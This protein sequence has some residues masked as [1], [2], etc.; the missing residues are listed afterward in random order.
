MFVTTYGSALIG[1]EAKK[2]HIEVNWLLTGKASTLVGLPDSAIRESLERI[3]S[4]FKT[5]GY[6]FPRTK[7]VINL[8]PADIRKSGTAFDLPIAIGILAASGQLKKV[9]DLQK[10]LLMG[11]LALDGSI[12]SIRGALPIALQAKKDGFTG[13]ILPAENT[14]EAI[15]IRSIDII[16]ASHL[17]EIV[18][19][20]SEQLEIKAIVK[21]DKP[22]EKEKFNA[23][24]EIKETVIGQELAKRALEIAAAG[25]HHLLLYGAPGAGKT[26]LARRLSLLLPALSYPE[27]IETSLIHSV[28]GHGIHPQLLTGKRP[29]RD[30]HHSISD[31]GLIGG[32]RNLQPGEISLAHHGVL[33]LDELPEFKRNVLEALRQPLEERCIV[34]ARAGHTC[35]YPCSFLLVAAMNPCPCGYHGHPTIPCSCT[36]GMIQRY[37]HRI[38]GPLLDR[39]DLHVEVKPLGANELIQ[40]VNADNNKLL[41]TLDKIKKAREIQAIRWKTIPHF[42]CNAQANGQL[43]HTTSKIEEEGLKILE[44]AAIKFGYSARVLDRLL[45]VARTIAD[46]DQQASILPAH[47]AEAIQFRNII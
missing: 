30:P 46:L 10:Y 11:E 12:R 37:K 5:N 36:T 26:M 27:A 39:I 14:A 9:E 23:T 20:F 6:K 31:A 8:A 22:P 7:L 18:A 32:G 34:L 42:Y 17:N 15:L 29:F 38:S 45:K 3:E 1:I 19:L 21:K 40:T 41:S 47:F 25:G 2:I 16:G 43:I 24:T 33:F 13:V 4:A 28:T 35:H 44:K